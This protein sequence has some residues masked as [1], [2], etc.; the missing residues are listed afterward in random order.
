MKIELIVATDEAFGIGKDGGI[1]W[2]CKEDLSNFRRQTMGGALIVGRHTAASL[3]PLPGRRIITLSTTLPDAPDVARSAADAVEIAR[4]WGVRRA[5]FA[6]GVEVY[7][8]GVALCERV[9]H[10]IIE[11]DFGCDRFIPASIFDGWRRVGFTYSPTLPLP[12][13]SFMRGYTINELVREEA[14][15]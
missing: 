10:T 7:K 4:D 13:G 6:G 8:A 11:G 5:F 1:P 15:R 2:K 9:H 14:A 12:G 3:P